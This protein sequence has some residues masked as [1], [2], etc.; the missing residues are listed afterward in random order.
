M[1][2]TEPHTI[3]LAYTHTHTHTHWFNIYVFSTVRIQMFYFY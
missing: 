2:K 3:I 1:H